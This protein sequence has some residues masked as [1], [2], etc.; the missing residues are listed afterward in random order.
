MIV[1]PAILAAI[2]LGMTFAAIMIC[3]AVA[4]RKNMI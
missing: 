2:G 4:I 3:L 1:L